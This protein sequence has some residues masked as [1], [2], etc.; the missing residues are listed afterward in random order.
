MSTEINKNIKFSSKLD[1]KKRRQKISSTEVKNALNSIV[2][3]FVN[4]VKNKHL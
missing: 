3:S 1:I 2:N 4:A